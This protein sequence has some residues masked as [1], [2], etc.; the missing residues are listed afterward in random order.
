MQLR[1]VFLRGSNGSLLLA[2]NSAQEKK[3]LRCRRLRDPAH[4]AG[5][6]FHD[7]EFNTTHDSGFNTTHH[8]SKSQAFVADGNAVAI[9]FPVLRLQYRRRARFN[10]FQDVMRDFLWERENTRL[11]ATFWFDGLIF[12]ERA[13][14][15]AQPEDLG[16]CAQSMKKLQRLC[17]YVFCKGKHVTCA[18]CL[19]PWHRY[20]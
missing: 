11:P 18:L 7:S 15:P 20:V 3:Q 13:R 4:S 5:P 19:T 6:F 17:V 10:C 14:F 2:S 12:R 8:L 1:K 16:V 9:Q